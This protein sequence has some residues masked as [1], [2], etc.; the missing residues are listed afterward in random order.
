MEGQG[1]EDM[2]SQWRNVGDRPVKLA[3]LARA[4]T[5]DDDDGG[6]VGFN[7]KTFFIFELMI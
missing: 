5:L 2:G 1:R 7:D 4:W 6:A 3:P